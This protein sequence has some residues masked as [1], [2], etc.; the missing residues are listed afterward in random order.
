MWQGAKSPDLS[1]KIVQDVWV[2]GIPAAGEKLAI[3][4]AGCKPTRIMLQAQAE[5]LRLAREKS[6]LH[7]GQGL[8][9]GRDSIAEASRGVWGRNPPQPYQDGQQSGRQQGQQGEVVIPDRLIPVSLILAFH[10]A[11]AEAL[12]PS[13]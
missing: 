8:A 10:G 1:G 2:Q 3:K 11:S 7:V 13:N 12:R 4:M 9:H 6:P 5:V